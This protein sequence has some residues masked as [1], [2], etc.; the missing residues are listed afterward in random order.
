MSRRDVTDM[1]LNMDAARLMAA[2][3]RAKMLYENALYFWSLN[4]HLIC[5][6]DGDVEEGSLNV[7]EKLREEAKEAVRDIEVALSAVSHDSQALIDAYWDRYAEMMAAISG[8][9]R[10][11]AENCKL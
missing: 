6:E 4:Q 7:Y 11:D 1:Y 10:E 2:W 5:D 8:K 9:A 3:E